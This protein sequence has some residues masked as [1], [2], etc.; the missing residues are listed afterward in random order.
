MPCPVPVPAEELVAR[1]KSVTDTSVDK[2]KAAPEPPVE[3]PS[4]T[5]SP[6]DD[7]LVDA[8]SHDGP[9]MDLLSGDEPIADLGTVIQESAAEEI[10]VD[11][12]PPSEPSPDTTDA[13][14]GLAY[15]D[16]KTADTGL[17]TVVEEDEAL[18]EDLPSQDDSEQDAEPWIPDYK[19]PTIIITP[20]SEVDPEDFA[21]QLGS[22]QEQEESEDI[23]GTDLEDELEP[24]SEHEESEYDDGCN[25]GYAEYPACQVF[26][27]VSELPQNSVEARVDAYHSPI[28]TTGMLWSDD[29]GGDLGPL[30]FTE[31]IPHVEEIDD[32]EA[33]ALEP[34]EAV[35]IAEQSET[36]D[37]PEHNGV[38]EFAIEG[39]MLETV[40]TTS[41]D[42]NGMRFTHLLP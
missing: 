42:S 4:V 40:T 2:V 6:S 23:I 11:V 36:A 39:E 5:A 33:D 30:P 13:I 16:E 17:E 31:G 12:C 7:M 3:E 27:I 20:P 8:P 32:L 38:Q 15:V 29:E 9:A 18:V 24:E 41:E 21:Q 25:L 37:V 22:E 34:S 26:E 14:V 10:P 35:G 1:L 28:T 19:V